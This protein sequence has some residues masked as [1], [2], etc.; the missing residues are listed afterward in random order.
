[1]HDWQSQSLSPY[2]DESVNFSKKNSS[3]I[4]SSL[5]SHDPRLFKQKIPKSFILPESLRPRQEIDSRVGKMFLASGQMS[6]NDPVE[7][8]YQKTDPLPFR[9]LDVVGQLRAELPIQDLVG[10]HV[11]L[12]LAVL[13]GL[14]LEKICFDLNFG[15]IFQPKTVSKPFRCAFKRQFRIV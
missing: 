1:M 7:T 10:V 15:G 8:S 12:F 14:Q 6:Q 4:A 11:L 2:H 5:H 13:R 3:T 9:L